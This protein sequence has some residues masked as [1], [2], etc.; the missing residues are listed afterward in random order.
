MKLEI[1]DVGW[2]N[3]MLRLAKEQNCTL[4]RC[5]LVNGWLQCLVTV[6]AGLWHL[7]VSH[8]RRYPTWDEIKSVRYS[9]LPDERTFAILFPPIAQYVNLHP[10]CFHLHEV[11]EL[12]E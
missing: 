7:S 11:P 12:H 9:L 8:P 10:N 5:C 3:A 1:K 6:D 2:P 4:V